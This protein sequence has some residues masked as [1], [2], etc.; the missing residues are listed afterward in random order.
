VSSTGNFHASTYQLLSAGTVSGPFATVSDTLSAAL[1]QQIVH[2][3]RGRSGHHAAHDAAGAANGA[4]LMVETSHDLGF[5]T[6][7]AL[8]GLGNTSGVKLDA[9]VRYRF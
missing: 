7:A 3:D 4:V 9:G 6:D 5:F 1:A 8:V 2:P